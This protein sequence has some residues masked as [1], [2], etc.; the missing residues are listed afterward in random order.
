MK[1]HEQS[2]N[3]CVLT[4]RRAQADNIIFLL[5]FY[6][7]VYYSRIHIHSTPHHYNIFPHENLFSFH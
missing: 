1:T 2:G 7:R 3:S 6:K 5:L 4:S